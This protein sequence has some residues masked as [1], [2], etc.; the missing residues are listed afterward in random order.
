MWQ[1]KKLCAEVVKIYSKKKS[2]FVKKEK[3]ILC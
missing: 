3:E 2:I 1:E